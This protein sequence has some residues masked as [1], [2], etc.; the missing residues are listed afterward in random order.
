MLKSNSDCICLGVNEQFH[1][2]SLS[3]HE[4]CQGAENPDYDS[5]LL[6]QIFVAIGFHVKI[7]GE[8]TSG[9]EVGRTDGSN[10]SEPLADVTTEAFSAYVTYGR[11]NITFIPESSSVRLANLTVRIR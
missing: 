11:S 9:V 8:E 2:F 5:L 10:D 4:I 3:Q 1:V 6:N 7:E